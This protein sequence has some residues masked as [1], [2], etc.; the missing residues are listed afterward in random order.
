MR[1]WR[2]DPAAVVVIAPWEFLWRIALAGAAD[3]NR[4][5]VPRQS[6]ARVSGPIG[7][8]VGR[9]L[10]DAGLEFDGVRIG[11][12]CEAIWHESLVRSWWQMPQAR[13]RAFGAGPEMLDCGATRA[14]MGQTSLG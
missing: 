11:C 3:A 1:R 4:A 8:V 7:D 6:L 14:G 9:R 12:S 10:R 2:V 13:R 5:A